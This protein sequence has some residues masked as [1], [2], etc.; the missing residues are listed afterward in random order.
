MNLDKTINAT[1]ICD[2]VTAINNVIAT[3]TKGHIYKESGDSSSCG[4]I[5]FDSDERSN[6]TTSCD[7]V[8]AINATATSTESHI[9]K[10]N[11]DSSSF[12]CCSN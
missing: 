10:K 6:A 9:Y 8:N 4:T 3:S 12:S 2:N 1:K 7:V 5:I 11:N